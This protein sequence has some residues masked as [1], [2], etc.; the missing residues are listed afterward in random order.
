MQNTKVILKIVLVLN[1]LSLERGTEFDTQ[2]L[3]NLFLSGKDLNIY[4][5]V[6]EKWFTSILKTHDLGIKTF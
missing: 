5:R 6:F 2:L 1:I 4:S 3:Q